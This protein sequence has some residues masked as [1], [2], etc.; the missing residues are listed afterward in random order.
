MASVYPATCAAPHGPVPTDDRASEPQPPVAAAV[1]SPAVVMRTG[2]PFQLRTPSAMAGR[3]AA[4]LSR[5]ELAKHPPAAWVLESADGAGPTAHSQRSGR[6]GLAT[7][8]YEAPL[9]TGHGWAV[10]LG[11]PLVVSA[12]SPPA[13]KLYFGAPHASNMCETWRRCR[14]TALIVARPSTRAGGVQAPAG[15]VA[16]FTLPRQ[17]A[18]SIRASRQPVPSRRGGVR[19]LSE[20]PPP[21][22]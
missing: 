5:G 6:L 12:P 13:C 7:G 11:F 15:C 1:A 22:R 8:W 18:P 10:G 4:S 20:I 21:P 9:S 2:A 14:G 3:P 17:A 19:T 16:A